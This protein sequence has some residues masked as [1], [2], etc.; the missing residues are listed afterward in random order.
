MSRSKKKSPKKSVAPKTSPAV[1]EEVPQEPPLCGSLI[2]KLFTTP[3]PRGRF[4]LGAFERQFKSEILSEGAK[5]LET[6]LNECVAKNPAPFV[7]SRCK[8]PLRNKGLKPK[9]LTTSLGEIVFRRRYG[10]CEGCK[11]GLFPDDEMF[12]LDPSSLSPEMQYI[13][14]HFG[15]DTDFSRSSDLLYKAS[16]VRVPSK[17]VERTTERVGEDLRV[18]ETQ[19]TKPD[20]HPSPRGRIL[21][22]SFDG[23]GC[24]ICARELLER[25]GKQ[26]DGSARTREVKIALFWEANTYTFEGIPIRD[27]GS[28][29]CTG[30]IESA[31]SSGSEDSAFSQR[32]GREIKRR[33]AD[34][35]DQI[36]V[37]GDG[38]AW[39][40]NT[41]HEHFP[42]AV[43]ILDRFHAKERLSNL[44]KA[45]HGDTEKAKA[46]RDELYEDLDSG[47]TDILLW[48]IMVYAKHFSQAKECHTYFSNNR[49]R[50]NYPEY[51]AKGYCTSSGVT[52]AACKSVVGT[53]L[54]RSG[55]HWSVRGANAITALRTYQMSGRFESF[56]ESRAERR[57]LGMAA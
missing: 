45:I 20:I 30:A 12:G 38:A 15:A 2:D 56:W 35:A 48:K 21:Y 33:R 9:T 24:P 29:S 25:L 41:A 16:L 57:A 46:W 3:R 13:V 18:Y 54:K 42:N 22:S 53:R 49:H 4:D 23:T 27:L 8:R 43:C 39:I 37:I 5:R 11:N 7:C 26:L 47:R 50:M 10:F 34:E 1:S 36:V 31:A 51:R 6:A 44:S 40:W 19:D 32:V 55:M 14:S 28:V 17:Q 52:E